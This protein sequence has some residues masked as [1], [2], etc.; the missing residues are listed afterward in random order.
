M[1]PERRLTYDDFHEMKYLR[2]PGICVRQR[3]SDFPGF[4]VCLDLHCCVRVAASH[5]SLQQIVQPKKHVPIDSLSLEQQRAAN[6]SFLVHLMQTFGVALLPGDRVL[7]RTGLRLR[8]VPNLR[9]LHTPFLKVFV[10]G[11]EMVAA[12]TPSRECRVNGIVT[13]LRR[14]S[15]GLLG[16]RGAG[17]PPPRWRPL[18]VAWYDADIDSD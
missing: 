17:A 11:L 7:V 2:V 1:C 14:A 5:A 18:A 3:A 13:K 8:T 15:T 9:V 12:W 4:H 6:A 10:H 16:R